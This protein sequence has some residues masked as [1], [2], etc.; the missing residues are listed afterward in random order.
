MSG[1][2]II[3]T[4]SHGNKSLARCILHLS[5][6]SFLYS[7]FCMFFHNVRKCLKKTVSFCM[8]AKIW[9]IKEY[10]F[11]EIDYSIW[12]FAPKNQYQNSYFI[13]L[14]KKSKCHFNLRI[15]FWLEKFNCYKLNSLRSHIVETSRYPNKGSSA[16][17]SIWVGPKWIGPVGLTHI[18][19][20]S[21]N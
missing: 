1:A 17:F 8:K 12:I 11:K 7:S 3:T 18:P 14:E 10:F 6:V 16:V 5:F 13:M 15:D 4:Q 20:W 21:T 19:T 2:N 9:R